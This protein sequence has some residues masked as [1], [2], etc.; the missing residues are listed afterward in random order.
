MDKVVQIFDPRYYQ[1]RDTALKG[2][3]TEV[4]LIAANRGP[5]RENELNEFL[6][7]KENQVF[8]DRVYPF[9]L[10]EGMRDFTS[11][12]L[13]TRIAKGESVQDQ[14]P[15]VIEKFVTATGATVLCMK[16]AV[17]CSIFF[18]ASENG[19]RRNAISSYWSGSRA[20]R[21]KGES[22]FEGWSTP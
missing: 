18:T 6:S 22:T 13:R 10:P 12:E 1:D 16:I 14:L 17:S 20:K 5:L 21:P 11:T 15:E 7:R 9:S 2:L 4:Q 19:Q 8:E 3:F